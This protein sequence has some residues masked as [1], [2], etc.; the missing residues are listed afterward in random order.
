MG[1]AESGA[2]SSRSDLNKTFVKGEKALL[3]ELDSRLNQNASFTNNL[4]GKSNH[5]RNGS[6]LADKII[7]ICFY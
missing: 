2:Q 4:N 7:P 5:H 6:K 3:E 1:N